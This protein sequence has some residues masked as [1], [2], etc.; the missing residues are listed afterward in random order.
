MAAATTIGTYQTVNFHFR[1]QFSFD[2]SSTSVDI[3]FQSVTGMDST[4]ETENLNEGGENLFTHVLPLRRKFGPLV[5]KRGLLFPGD[6]KL[7]DQFKDVFQNDKV[8]PFKL[9]TIDLLDQDHNSL[10]QWRI[11]NVWPLSWKIGELNAM[12]GAVLIET[13]ELNY[14]HLVFVKSNAST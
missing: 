7:T 14:N 12:E 9:V 1:V 4:L 3:H 11:D 8:K 10:V 6:S 2:M 5:L 13:M